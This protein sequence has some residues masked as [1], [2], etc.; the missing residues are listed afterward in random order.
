MK[1]QCQGRFHILKEGERG[2]M[3][4]YSYNGKRGSGKTAILKKLFSGI[5]RKWHAWGRTER[6]NAG[7][8]LTVKDN[9][10]YVGI[11]PDCRTIEVVKELFKKAEELGFDVLVVEGDRDDVANA[12]KAEVSKRKSWQY[13][14]RLKAPRKPVLPYDQDDSDVQ[15]IMNEIGI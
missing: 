14:S 15:T 3:I 1:V 9:A 10:R 12:I 5:K 11:C 4:V 8:F 7:K 6:F 2:G 13:K